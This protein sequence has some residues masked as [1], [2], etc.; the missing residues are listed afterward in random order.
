MAGPRLWQ[1]NLQRR[2]FQRFSWSQT[3][4]SGSD[5]SR[6]NQIVA[7]AARH[8]FPGMYFGREFAVAGGLMTYSASLTEAY[9]L[10]GGYVSHILNGAKPCRPPGEAADEI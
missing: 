3:I 8:S 7:L 2:R 9:R 10:A 6:R 5:L 4:L 1:P